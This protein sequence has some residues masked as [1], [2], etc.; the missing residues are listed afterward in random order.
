MPKV[1]EDFIDKETYRAIKN[2]SFAEFNRY[3][4]TVYS[5]GYVAGLNDSSGNKLR[6]AA[7]KLG[8]AVNS[9][10]EKTNAEGAP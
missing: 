5:A 4:F 10:L 1:I 2:L 6:E 7:E 3:L 8:A 9:A